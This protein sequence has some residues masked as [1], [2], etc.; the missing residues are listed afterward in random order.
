MIAIDLC[1]M[2]V[3]EKR[4]MIKTDSIQKL[5]MNMNIM[6]FKYVN[7]ILTRFFEFVFQL[8]GKFLKAS[9]D[10]MIKFLGRMQG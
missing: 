8:V 4:A 7:K 1:K 5:W 10:G 9:R 3:P 6:C 2:T